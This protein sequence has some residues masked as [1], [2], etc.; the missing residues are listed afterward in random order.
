MPQASTPDDPTA[1][2]APRRRP[3]G[4]TG[5]R[6]LLMSL[7][8]EYVL[9]HGGTV[10]TA[11]VLRV[12]DGL[13]IEEKSARQALARTAADGWIAAERHGRRT[14]WALTPPGR[15]LLTEGAARIYGF[16]EPGP[17]WD[18]RW[19]V[20]MATVP[21]A[22]R[23]LRHQL[24]TRLTWAGFGSPSPG[25]WIS[26]HP[27]RAPEADTI[28]RELGLADDAFSFHGTF[29]GTGS[30][31]AMVDRAWDLAAIDAEYAEFVDRFTEL[32]PTPGLPVVLAQVRLVHEWRRFPFL[33]PQLPAALLP[34]T[35]TGT[36]AA[37]LYNTRRQTWQTTGE[38]AW[39]HLTAAAE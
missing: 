27:E 12:L 20:L 15:R 36:K 34:A 33:D 3:A 29:G 9:P 28:L 17:E 38:T 5:A 18:G 32:R 26:P 25:V 2:A 14:R 16:G 35:W 39:H 24:R 19:L 13:G 4:A 22:Q 21:E 6:S 7:L 1:A 23:K 30:E 37:D 8:G 31:R 10:W 11:T